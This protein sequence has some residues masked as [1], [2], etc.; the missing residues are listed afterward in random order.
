MESR[1]FRCKWTH[2]L[3]IL[4]PLVASSEIQLLRKLNH[5]NLIKL[6]DVIYDNQKE[7]MYIIMDHCVAVMQELLESIPAKKFPIHQ[8]HG[9]VLLSFAHFTDVGHFR[10]FSQLINGLEYLH[11]QGIIHKDIKPG[12]LL[13]TNGGVIKISDLGVSE[14]FAIPVCLAN[15]FF[16]MLDRFQQDDIISIS[17]GSPAFQPPE[18]ADGHAQFSGFKVDIWASGVTLYNITTGKYPFQ[19][20]NIYR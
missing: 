13:I 16:Q 20:D 5:S 7:K 19:G 4:T 18:I 17:Q 8:A 14:V 2:L 10:Y 3:A 9:L 11:S 1:M 6:Y 12:N 15:P